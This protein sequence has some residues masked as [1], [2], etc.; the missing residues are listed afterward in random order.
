M[1]LAGNHQDVPPA[2]LGD[3]GGDRLAAVADLD[4]VR[5]GGK[6]R[7]ADLGRRFAAR[8][9]VRDID[10]IGA[11]GR[12]LTHQRTLAAVAV[13]AGA[14]D[15]RQPGFGMRAQGGQHGR[16]RIRGVG[17]IDK[18]HRAARRLTDPL[19]P[20]GHAI[21]TRQ[22][23]GCIRYRRAARDRQPERRQHI[24]RLELADQRQIDFVRIAEHRQ[25]DALAV[26]GR[27]TLD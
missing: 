20:A 9:V 10:E 17:V 12:H 24:H 8:I 19:H 13:A 15:D 5:R 2:Q 7:A 11:F 6:D 21:E 22:D 16:Q 26:A 27:M 3:R 14:E 1:T 4:R 23:T 18:D 25:A